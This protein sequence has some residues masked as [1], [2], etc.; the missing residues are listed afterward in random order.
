MSRGP[1]RIERAIRALFDAHPDLAFVTDELAEHCY[2]GQVIGK[3]HQVAVL[4]AARNVLKHDPDWTVG[5]LHDH[6][7]RWKFYNRDSLNSTLA[8]PRTSKRR[9]VEHEWTWVGVGRGFGRIRTKVPAGTAAAGTCRW[10]EANLP[11]YSVRE[12][13]FL[14]RLE[15]Q[16]RDDAIYDV[17][18]HRLLRNSDDAT[19]TRLLDAAHEIGRDFDTWKAWRDARRVWMTKPD[20]WLKRYQNYAVKAQETHTP[21]TEPIIMPP[22]PEAKRLADLARRLITE[23]DPDAIRAGLAE[24]ADALDQMAGERADAGGKRLRASVQAA[25]GH[26]GAS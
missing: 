26:H 5:Y 23:N 16:A 8:K 11:G 17:A 13:A 14:D 3:K 6:G 12:A 1:G 7:G 2:P 20:V 4:R 19:R 24:V 22:P 10:L 18:W 9:R 15:Q 21:V 25:G